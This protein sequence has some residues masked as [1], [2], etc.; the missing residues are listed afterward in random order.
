MKLQAPQEMFSGITPW[1]LFNMLT[2]LLSLLT[3]GPSKYFSDL[4]MARNG[5]LQKAAMFL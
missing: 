4:W 1:T 3:S 5:H 2:L